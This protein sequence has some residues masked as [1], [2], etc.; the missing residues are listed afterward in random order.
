MFQL[1]RQSDQPQI[2]NLSGNRSVSFDLSRLRQGEYVEFNYDENDKLIGIRK[3]E[4]FESYG[5]G[6][7]RAESDI[8]PGR[9]GQ[10]AYAG[11]LWHAR[12][13]GRQPI[14]KGQTAF[15]LGS[16]ENLTLFVRLAS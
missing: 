8:T 15:V 6:L 12:S 5:S 2:I 10:V 1:F 11:T 3:L 14:L 13:E 7:A 4:L 16:D 9:V